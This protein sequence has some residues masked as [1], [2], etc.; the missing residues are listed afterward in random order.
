M[1]EKPNRSVK[2][3]RSR[4]VRTQGPRRV[5]GTRHAFDSAPPVRENFSFA[6]NLL[7]FMKNL[8]DLLNF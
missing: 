3:S 1:A 4:R 2:G 7:N 5:A 8:I 6:K